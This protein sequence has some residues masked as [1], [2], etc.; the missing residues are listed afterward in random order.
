MRNRLRA[1]LRWLVDLAVVAVAI[2]CILHFSRRHVVACEWGRLRASCTVE[3]EDSLGRVQRAVIEGIRGAAYRSGN[4]VGLVTDA[5]NKDDL[6]LFGVREV[7]VADAASA[8]RLRAFAADRD[9][10]RIHIASGVEH[11]RLTTGA[12]LAA[13]L[14][15]GVATRRRRRELARRDA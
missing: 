10:D 8:E 4:V 13:L 7:E 2:A 5:A 9:P 1:I 6:A 14:V 11:P 12:I 15:Y 3:A